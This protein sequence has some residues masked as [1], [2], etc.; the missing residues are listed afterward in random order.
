[1]ES[2][3]EAFIE[4]IKPLSSLSVLVISEDA[5][6]LLPLLHSLFSQV[7]TTHSHTQSLHFFDEKH[8]DLVLL[9]TSMKAY[10]WLSL[11]HQLRLKQ[12]DVSLVLLTHLQEELNHDALINANAMCYLLKPLE[13]ET[14][15]FSLRNLIHKIELKK[16]T[17]F[18]HELK[19]KRKIQGIAL[20]TIQRVI[21]E[22]PSPIFAY[23][24]QEKILFFNKDLAKLF[25]NKKLDIPEMAHVWNIEDLFE[26]MPKEMHFAQ[27]K[28]GKSLELK[29]IYKDYAIQKIFIPTKFTV[30]LESEEEPFS[31]I[32]LTDIAPLLLQIQHMTYQQQKMDNYKEIIEELLAQKLFKESNKAFMHTQKTLKI[33]E[34]TSLHVKPLSAL[35]YKKHQDAALFETLTPLMTLENALHQAISAFLENPSLMTLI[36]LPRLLEH[37]AL[38]LKNLSEFQNLSNALYSL[39]DF[40]KGL[41]EEDIRTYTHEACA[42]L[43]KLLQYLTQWRIAIFHTEETEDIHAFDRVILSTVLEFQITLSHSKKANEMQPKG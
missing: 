7:Y 6:A 22:I 38:L 17:H 27:I 4:T 13:E 28:E 9:E 3:H 24:A 40:M 21:E 18:Y 30:A 8:S 15:R 42:S 10:N 35:A 29:Y 19:E 11:V 16:E 1:M 26:T 39:S 43:E 36:L 31:V 37:Y 41:E 5:S 2:K 20:Y 33:Q 14:L 12:H 23:N 32:V 34:K 25:H